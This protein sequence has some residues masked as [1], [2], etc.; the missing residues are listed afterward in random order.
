MSDKQDNKV[1]KASSPSSTG[2]AGSLVEGKVGA[3]YLLSMLGGH[4]GT[5]ISQVT[6]QSG[7]QTRV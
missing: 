2:P 7:E 5:S 3:Y 4:E 6:F 1:E